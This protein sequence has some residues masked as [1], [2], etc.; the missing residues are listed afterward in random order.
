MLSVRL[1]REWEKEEAGMLKP[2]EVKGRLPRSPVV[3]SALLEQASEETGAALISY[4]Q[5]RLLALLSRPSTNLKELTATGARAMS[6]VITSVASGALD[7]LVCLCLMEPDC[8]SR[9]VMGEDELDKLASALLQGALPRLKMLDLQG[10][11]FENAAELQPLLRALQSGAC[12]Q[13]TYLNPGISLWESDLV[14]LAQ[15]LNARAGLELPC[16]SVL[17]IDF[18]L[19]NFAHTHYHK[20]WEVLADVLLSPLC[21]ELEELQIGMAW[22]DGGCP[23]DRSTLDAVGR[24]LLSGGASCLR[25]LCI[26]SCDS[27]QPNVITTP[28]GEAFSSGAAPQLEEIL[29]DCSDFEGPVFDGLWQ[30]IRNGAWPRLRSLTL[31]MVMEYEGDPDWEELEDDE[32]VPKL[33]AAME[34]SGG[35]PEMETLSFGYRP[36]DATSMAALAG[37]LKRGVCPN[38]K[39]IDPAHR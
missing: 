28:L 10:V 7:G 34:A 31:W 11:F 8:G 25:K 37:A 17:I 4:R 20:K 33:M 39:V 9:E 12:P 3:S 38:L 30:A 22:V 2:R 13:L 18:S 32:E 27:W 26:G 5:E 23:L 6:G 21:R 36:L 35:R 1:P 19:P 15:A 29:F 14:A 24:Y 16:L